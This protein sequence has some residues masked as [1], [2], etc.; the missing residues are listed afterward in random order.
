LEDSVVWPD[1]SSSSS[2]GSKSIAEYLLSRTAPAD[3]AVTKLSRFVD[4]SSGI[5]SPSSAISRDKSVSEGR[6]PGN[7]GR[8]SRGGIT[9]GVA[10]NEL[11]DWC[12]LVD[13]MLMVLFNGRERKFEYTGD[14]P[15]QI[16]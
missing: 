14:E 10:D 4:E 9:G 3:R 11:P 12:V 1:G 8:R 13:D 16:N 2:T 15:V 5:H 6:G 7:A